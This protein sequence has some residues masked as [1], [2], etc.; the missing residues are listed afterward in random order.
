M[1]REGKSARAIVKDKG[2]IQISD[3]AEIAAIIE[4]VLKGN[5]EQVAKY[6]KGREQLLGF[7][8][9]QVMKKTK[10]KANPRLVNEILKRAIEKT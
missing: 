9:G 8:V 3:E 7:F 10:G 6:K 1:Y 4:Q 2:L 5:P